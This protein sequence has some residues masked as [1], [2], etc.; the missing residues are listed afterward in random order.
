[1]SR[2]VDHFMVC[3]YN[4]GVLAGT[5]WLV[6]HGWS[7]WWFLFALICLARSSKDET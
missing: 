7:G 2:V 4:F 1:M 5:A 3:L 6:W